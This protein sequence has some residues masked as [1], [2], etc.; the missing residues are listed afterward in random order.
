MAQ[1]TWAHRPRGRQ[2][3]R[4][5]REAGHRV[6]Q[7][8]YR[9]ARRTPMP[10]SLRTELRSRLTWQS[11]L[12]TVPLAQILMGRQNKVPAIEFGHRI[13]DPLWSS[14]RV[15]DGPHADLLRRERHGPLT[16]VEIL[17]TS[18][19]DLARSCIQLAGQFFTATDSAGIVRVARDFIARSSGSLLD[20]DVAPIGG[21]HTPPGRPIEVAPVRDSSC[22]QVIDGHHRVAAAAV[23]GQTEI[24]VRLNRWAVDTGLQE[25]LRSMSWIGGDP[26]LYQ[27]LEAPEVADWPVVRGCEDRLALMLDFLAD[28]GLDA[29]GSSYLDVA[30]C[31]GWFVA[32]MGEQGFAATGLERDPLAPLLG[33]VA[34]GV[35][36]DRITTGEAIDFLRLPRASSDV[37]SCFSLLHHFVLGRGSTD[38]AGLLKALDGATRK[39][40]FL[41][42]GQAHE[43][44]FRTSLPEWEAEHIRRFLREHT[45]FDRIVD[46]GPDQDDKAPYSGNYGRHLFACVREP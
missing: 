44:W 9:A 32:R 4:A 18:Y 3:Q 17:G 35:P 11:G 40:L 39:V 7:G 19:A 45:T 10:R 29:A 6:A 37:V 27:P 20:A 12:V 28:R 38:G 13:G 24:P 14:R 21:H 23:A 1:I 43:E 2:L 42:T 26:M 5:A 25:L 30:S 8:T 22:Y 46:L 31:Y 34:L 41:D 33:E 36:A 15:I 16:D